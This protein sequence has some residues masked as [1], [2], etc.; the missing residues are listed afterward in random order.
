MNEKDLY[1]KIQIIVTECNKLKNKYISK[2]NSL[3]DYC[4]IFSQSKEECN[5]LED[6][7]QKIGRL[8]NKT[9]TGNLY[10]INQVETECGV[11]R[12]LKI[13]I[14][15]ITRPEMGDI[16][17]IIDNYDEFKEE[18]LQEENFKL[19]QRE[20]FEMIELMDNDFNVRVYFPNPPVTKQFELL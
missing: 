18:Y 20:T 4:C 14:P 15:D 16:D 13:R 11:L 2:N 8:L 3:I 19:I 1:K 17:F 7:V 9:A 5:E 10:Q 6:C 12:V